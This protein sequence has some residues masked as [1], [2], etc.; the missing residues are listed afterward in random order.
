MIL[1]CQFPYRT[2]Q[3][4]FF[5]A[6]IFGEEAERQG[7]IESMYVQLSPFSGGLLEVLFE[8]AISSPK[9]ESTNLNPLRPS[10]ADFLLGK[11][12]LR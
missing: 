3:N 7:E 6:V 5:C 1:L 4:F 11:H 2:S 8:E 9:K 12:L 10:R